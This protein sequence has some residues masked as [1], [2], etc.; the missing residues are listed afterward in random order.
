MGLCHTCIDVTSKTQ[1][2]S[3]S[4][5]TVSLPNGQ[6]IT[7]G[8]L[9]SWVSVRYNYNQTWTQGIDDEYDALIPSSFAQFTVLSFTLNGCTAKSDSTSAAWETSTCTPG[10]QNTGRYTLN[11]VASSCA[12][13]SCIKNLHGSVSNGILQESLISTIPAPKMDFVN[14]AKNI[15]I[16]NSPCVASDQKVYTSSNISSLPANAPNTELTEIDGKNV[17]VP[18]T[19]LYQMYGLHARAFDLFFRSYF[20][21][22]CW[23]YDQTA[24]VDSLVCE[25]NWHTSTFF[26]SGFASPS[27]ISSA[28]G[29]LVD[30]ATNT[31]R[32]AGRTWDEAAPAKVEGDVLRATV[33]ARVEMKWLL[34]PIVV[35]TLTAVLLA[36]VIAVGWAE[37]RMEGFVPVWKGSVLPLL[38]HGFGRVEGDYGD[39]GPL[40]LKELERR[41]EGVEVKFGMGQMHWGLVRGA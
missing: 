4:S 12:I 3:G 22:S 23:Y 11:V 5:T 16:V 15:T 28:V 31:F 6:N 13:Y 19:C 7:A 2:K 34:G 33:C 40:T 21:N 18:T 26:A 9:Q 25:T 35:V 17:S 36:M 27:T 30:A 10:L 20:N 38:W 1:Q 29:R 24:R 14:I 8:A 32:L 41:A 39:A 37:N